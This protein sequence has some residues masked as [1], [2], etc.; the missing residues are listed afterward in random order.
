MGFGAPPSQHQGQ[1]WQADEEGLVLLH[2]FAARWLHRGQ[3][4]VQVAGAK[5]SGSPAHAHFETLATAQAMDHTSMPRV[6]RAD[7][8]TQ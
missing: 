6:P 8:H 4:G 5:W 2:T 1:R 7:I 3:R